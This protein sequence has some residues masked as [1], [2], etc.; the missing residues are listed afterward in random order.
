MDRVQKAVECHDKGF[1]CSQSVFSS[2]CDI[3]GADPEE[4]LRVS[5]GFGGGMGRRQE[6]C[7]A[8]SGAYMLIGMKYGKVKLDDNQAKEKTYELVR[9]FADK[10]IERNGS[11]CCRDLLGVD[12]I[13]DDRK[14]VKERT[15]MICPKMIRDAAEIIEEILELK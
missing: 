9:R 1:N 7:G 4:A 15:G 3:F 13:N 6:T 12:L 11:V 10:F 8:V 5:C 14:A 2:Y